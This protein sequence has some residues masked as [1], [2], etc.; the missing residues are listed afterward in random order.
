[1]AA[2]RRRAPMIARAQQASECQTGSFVLLDGRVCKCVRVAFSIGAVHIRAK[3]IFTGALH[4]KEYAKHDYV[5]VPDVTRK[6]YSCM[7]VDEDS[8]KA[9][10]RDRSG[11]SRSSL[12]IPAE[13]WHGKLKFLDRLRASIPISVVVMSACGSEKVVSAHQRKASSGA[14]AVA[15][16]GDA[17]GCPDRLRDRYSVLV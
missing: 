6:E 4:E 7:S 3:D 9:K 2:A 12:V 17:Q 15:A 16:S 8:G 10:L 1:M 13:S 14:E 5:E 11:E